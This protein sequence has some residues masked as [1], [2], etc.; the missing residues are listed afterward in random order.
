VSNDTPVGAQ[1]TGLKRSSSIVGSMKP[2]QDRVTEARRERT[3]AIV[4]THVAALFARLPTLCC[5]SVH[6]E[7][8]V[9]DVATFTWPG[10]TDEENLYQAL[11]QALADLADE[12]PDAVALLRGRTFARAIH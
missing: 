4:A 7:L 5:F 3:E 2:S 10:H 6:P 9:I 11:M 1:E 8:E 12:R